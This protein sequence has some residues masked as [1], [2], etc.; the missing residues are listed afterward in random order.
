NYIK[1]NDN[2]TL[3]FNQ[4]TKAIQS[5]QVAS[6]L[7]DPKEAVDISVRFA[8]LPD[9]TNHVANAM[10]TAVS[11]KLIVAIQNSDYQNFGS[12]AARVA[13]GGYRPARLLCHRT[14]RVGSAPSPGDAHTT[15]IAIS[16]ARR[17]HESQ[18]ALRRLRAQ[19]RAAQIF[20]RP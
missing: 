6:Y 17:R 18:L 12:H 7:Q 3:V 11:K 9:G 13:G 4:Q 20:G 10:I 2:V 5:V 14:R 8:Q 19:R 15:S 1:P 16:Q